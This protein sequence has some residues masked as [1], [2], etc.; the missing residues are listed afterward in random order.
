MKGFYTAAMLAE[1][2]SCVGIQAALA[3][4]DMPEF[5]KHVARVARSLIALGVVVVWVAEDGVVTSDPPEAFA[6]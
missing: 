5:R 2:G 4:P 3:L 1:A 6:R